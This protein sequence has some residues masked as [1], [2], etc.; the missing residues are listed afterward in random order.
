MPSSLHSF[1]YTFCFYSMIGLFPTF[2]T[3]HIGSI[4][5]FEVDLELW[6]GEE[7]HEFDVSC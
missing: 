2:D 7:C 5:A 3:M 1:K 4:A 6:P